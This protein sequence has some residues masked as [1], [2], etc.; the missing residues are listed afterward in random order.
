MPTKEN[1]PAGNGTESR[2]TGCNH[3]IHGLKQRRAATYRL[4]PL[5]CVDPWTCRHYD[6]Q[7]TE[8]YVDGYRDAV[9]HLD[10]HGLLAAPLIPEMRALWRRSD[11]D[12][13][14]V[15]QIAER[16]ERVA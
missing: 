15:R 1:R 16:W 12:R 11:D 14:L 4:P 10:A 3:Y 8:Q 6:D 5:Y 13:R 7:V 9:L 2:T